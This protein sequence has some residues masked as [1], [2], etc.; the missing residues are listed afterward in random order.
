MRQPCPSR[1]LKLSL[2]VLGLILLGPAPAPYADDFRITSISVSNNDVRIA[3]N[4]PAGSNYVVQS[5]TPLRASGS[6]TFTDVSPAIAVLGVGSQPTDY[7]HMG[8][9]TNSASRFYR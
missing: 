4:A 9:L 2:V 7:T 5:V 6:N 8:G 3:W 1:F